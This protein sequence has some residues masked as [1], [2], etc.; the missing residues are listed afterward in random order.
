MLTNRGSWLDSQIIRWSEHPYWLFFWLAN[1][2]LCLGLYRHQPLRAVITT[3]D[4]WPCWLKTVVPSVSCQ[5]YPIQG[6]PDQ[7]ICDV[8]TKMIHEHLERFSSTSR[9]LQQVQTN[10]ITCSKQTL[11]CKVF[12]VMK[13]CT[14]NPSAVLKKVHLLQFTVIIEV[15]QWSD[16]TQTPGWISERTHG[17]AA[18][19][20][21]K[22]MQNNCKQ[23]SRVICSCFMSLSG[24]VQSGCLAPM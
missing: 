13:K 19:M 10:L 2:A 3:A 16:H 11:L 18:K 12:G 22:E 1:I 14:L 8:S 17:G 5:V 24:L 7:E 6:F 20:S 15:V 4:S 9:I 23:C 21:V